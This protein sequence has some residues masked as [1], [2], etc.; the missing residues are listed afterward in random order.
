[1]AFGR[2]GLKALRALPP[3]F[4]PFLGEMASRALVIMPVI[5]Y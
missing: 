4:A 1:M 2:S 5:L 3:E